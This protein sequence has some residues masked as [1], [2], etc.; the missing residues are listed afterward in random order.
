MELGEHADGGAAGPRR[1][2]AEH[3]AYDL[4]ALRKDNAF[5]LSRGA[6]GEEDHVRI[7]FVHGPHTASGPGLWRRGG[8]EVADRHV[9]VV[10]I[11]GHHRRGVGQ[12]EQGSRLVLLEVGVD[13]DQ[14]RS[15]VGQGEEQGHGVHRVVAPPGDAVSTAHPPGGEH[16]GQMFGPGSHFGKGELAPVGHHGGHSGRARRGRG[17]DLANQEALHPVSP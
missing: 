2:A 7:V 17:D 13:R 1:H 14:D 5:G 3:G 12:F 4:G 16:R 8:Q 11:I 15:Q 10:S 6:A 9:A